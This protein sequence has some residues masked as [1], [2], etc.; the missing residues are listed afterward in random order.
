MTWWKRGKTIEKFVNKS[1]ARKCCWCFKDFLSE[2][3]IEPKNAPR[4]LCDLSSGLSFLKESAAGTERHQK[5]SVLR[6]SFIR[7]ALSAIKK[8]GNFSMLFCLFSRRDLFVFTAFCPLGWRFCRE[9]WRKFP[10]KDESDTICPGWVALM[11]FCG[12]NWQKKSL[13]I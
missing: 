8:R 9:Q 3:F 2:R 6:K 1:Q 11:T 5:N 7:S 12:E 13:F 10:Q 4:S